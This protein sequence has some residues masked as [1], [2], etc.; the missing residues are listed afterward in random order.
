MDRE[1]SRPQISKLG[2]STKMDPA[3]QFL[4]IFHLD[5]TKIDENYIMIHFG[6]SGQKCEVH[7]TLPTT[8]IS[9]VT[10]TWCSPQG[11]QDDVFSSTLR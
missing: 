6:S 5:I 9:G 7:I 11:L 4:S 1:G 2:F 8:H 10:I 3:S